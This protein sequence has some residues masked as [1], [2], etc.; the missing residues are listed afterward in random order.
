VAGIWAGVLGLEKVSIHDDFFALGG[1]SLLATRVISR[2][3]YAFQ[4]SLPLRLL[5]ERA[6]VAGLAEQIAVAQLT[7][8]GIQ[9]PP[10]I[11]VERSTRQPLSFAQ[12]RL[13]FLDQL[14]P[15]SPF[16]NVARA[17][18]LS[19]RL[20]TAALSGA[21]AEIVRRHESLRTTF[22]TDAGTP[23]Q[24][25]AEF[26]AGP[27]RFVDLTQV[28]ESL[29]ELQAKEMAGTEI[30]QPFDL[31][32]DLLL[33]ALLLKLSD[34]EHVLI[35][36]LHHIA[37]DGW[38]IGVLFRELIVLYRN[39]VTGQTTTLP[40][41]PIQY[42]D[43]AV[44]QRQWLRGEVLEELLCYWRN[45]LAGA[46]QVLHLPTDKPRPSVQSFR[47]A[48]EALTLPA[49]LV[50]RL[51]NLSQARGATLFMTLLAGFQLVLSRFSGQQ[52][53]IVGTDVANRNRVETE[54]LIGFFTNLVP[55]RSR[56]APEL[57]FIDLLAQVRETTRGANPSGSPL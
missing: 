33:R 26:E 54:N 40:A 3:H 29:R 11:P 20:D 35:I 51:R 22:G 28:D 1:H 50:S 5:F 38:S 37:A 27:W 14:E 41:L 57:K 16:Y 44:W 47:G 39:S 15:G 49:V 56:I 4:I 53:L 17:V 25:T 2:I 10:L 55:L 19:G 46:P 21:I 23:F 43:Y 42:A 8:A 24:K 9:A 45:Q 48:H 18:R 52:D 34:E 36:T 7:Q 6:T 12:Q 30:A 32:R 13:W 31:T